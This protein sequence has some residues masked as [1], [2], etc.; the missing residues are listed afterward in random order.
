MTNP[1]TE[2]RIHSRDP[3]HVRE[4]LAAAF[5]VALG[6]E[7]ASADLAKAAEIVA[8]VAER[9]EQPSLRAALEAL[10]PAVF[11]TMALF[12][13]EA[14]TSLMLHF[15][16]LTHPSVL[17]RQ[18]YTVGDLGWPASALKEEFLEHAAPENP[19]R[20]ARMKDAVAAWKA[21]HPST[22]WPAF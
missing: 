5:A 7:A 12:S 21:L 11:G 20:D 4:D 18:G 14:Q 6:A 17:Q 3:E 15:E 8:S 9:N 22:D 1:T 19:E 10:G 16:A 2:R 13:Y